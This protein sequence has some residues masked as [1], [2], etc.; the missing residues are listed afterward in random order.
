MV[1]T[2]LDDKTIAEISEMT[3]AQLNKKP[4]AIL[5]GYCKKLGESGYGRANKSH[6]VNMIFN[7]GIRYKRNE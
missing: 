3:I 6:L 7:A 5:R 2:E 4:Q 1:R